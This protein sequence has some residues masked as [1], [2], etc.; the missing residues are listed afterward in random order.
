MKKGK[1]KLIE[2]FIADGF[3]YMFGNPGTVEEGFLDVLQNY[4]KLKYITCL[5]ESV[6]VAMAD[7]F[8][9]KSGRCALVQLH[10]A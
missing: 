3:Q 10:R 8:A 1:E 4:P 6:A 7:G 2:Q 9:R 5:H